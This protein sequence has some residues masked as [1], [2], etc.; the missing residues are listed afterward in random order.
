MKEVLPSGG[1][2]VAYSGDGLRYKPGQEAGGRGVRV[3]EFH[4]ACRPTAAG[5]RGLLGS[6]AGGPKEG[7][8]TGRNGDGSRK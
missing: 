2:H 4:R 5:G 3:V 8:A 1:R 6:T 7:R